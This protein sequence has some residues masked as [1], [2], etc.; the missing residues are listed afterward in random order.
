MHKPENIIIINMDGNIRDIV[1]ADLG[2]SEQKE[3][4]HYF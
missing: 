4:R 3:K 2:L 1:L